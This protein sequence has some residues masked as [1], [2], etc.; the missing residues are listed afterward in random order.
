MSEA[1]TRDLMRTLPALSIRQPWA[2]SILNGKDIENRTWSTGFRGRFLI[3][4]GKTMTCEE[5]EAWRIFVQG[6]IPEFDM[7]W[8]EC[9]KVAD[10][11]R[12]GIIGVADLVGCVTTHKSP[13]FCG[14]IGF[15]IANARPLAFVPCRGA[16]GFFRFKEEEAA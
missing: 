1:E 10:I 3:H 13:W 5:V 12:G 2:L 4:A 14:P 8:A 16:L 9:L 15:V 11:R 7:H 6:Y